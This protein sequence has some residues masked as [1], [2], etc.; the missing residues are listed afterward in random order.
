MN[1]IFFSMSELM[2]SFQATKE[3]VK[4][5]PN[6]DRLSSSETKPKGISLE[7]KKQCSEIGEPNPIIG[8]NERKVKG[9]TNAQ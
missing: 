5:E 4:L 6:G 2:S 3:I 7:K 8:K 9:K 1:R